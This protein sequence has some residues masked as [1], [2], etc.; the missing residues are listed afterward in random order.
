MAL[1][2]RDFKT[3]T[4]ER[5]AVPKHVTLVVP[6]YEN[7]VFLQR[8]LAHWDDQYTTTQQA[9]LSVIVVDDGSPIHPA[10]DYAP[11]SLHY[12]VNVRFFRIEQ[13]VRWNWLAARNIGMHHASDGWCLLT[14][15]DH[16]VSAETIG[17]LI[18]G[19]HDTRVVYCFAR[20]EHT[21]ERI[22]PHSA[23]FFLHRSTFWKTGGYDEALS[24]YYGTDGDFRR[25]LA[26]VAPLVLTP[27]TLIRH[28][29]VEDSSTSRYLRKQP[30]DAKVRTLIAQRKPGWK[31]KALSFPYH[32]VT[33]RREVA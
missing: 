15:M 30:E 1:W 20:Q 6:Y 19:V 3:V 29:Y 31:P 17:A 22:Q 8:Q 14:D 23:S 12:D 5:S 24:G 2:C 13:D 27:E 28:E 16:V 10:G 26:Q 21:G 9:M 18:Y 11:T 7:P 33:A 4:V 25:R 32:E